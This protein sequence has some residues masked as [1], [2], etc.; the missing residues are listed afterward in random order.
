MRSA[1]C[2]RRRPA[3]QA[4]HVGDLAGGEGGEREQRHAEED[5]ERPAQQRVGRQQAGDVVDRLND[6]GADHA[7]REQAQQA[8]GPAA[9]ARRRQRLALQR[10]LGLGQG[11][12]RR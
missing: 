11:L 10:G 8:A 1:A 2:A 9:L 12:L 4:A 7:Q 6:A 3:R 5:R